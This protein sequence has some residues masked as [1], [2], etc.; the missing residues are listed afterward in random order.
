MSH[1]FD[2]AI[3]RRKILKAFDP[4]NANYS[5][6]TPHQ[7]TGYI[8]GL[9][10]VGLLHAAAFLADDQEILIPAARYLY[11]LAALGPDVRNYRPDPSPGW[12]HDELSGFWVKRK[13]Q[14]MAGPLA[15]AIG[16]RLGVHIPQ[17]WT[18][19]F[20]KPSTVLLVHPV[21][22]GLYGAV[23][24]Y[25]PF[26]QALAQHLNTVFL[27]HM[28]EGLTPPDSL[29]WA[30][31][32]N[33]FY[34]FA[35]GEHLP[36]SSIR[37]PDLRPYEQEEKITHNSVVIMG[38]REPSPWVW[39]QWPYTECRGGARIDMEYTPTAHYVAYWLQ[40]TLE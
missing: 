36:L 30:A 17:K 10:H 28:A 14:A 37:L 8:D 16:R 22:A 31:K 19:V 34:A 33:P 12:Q 13:P 11:T 18:T 20:P 23:V 9:F 3:C 6:V 4:E 38:Q 21:I 40:K 7:Y 24:R 32:G 27:A 29:R 2:L 5:H 26:R 15:L 35:Y 1:P 39:K 25:T